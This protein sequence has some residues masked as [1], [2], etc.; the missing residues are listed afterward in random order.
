MAPGR[1]APTDAGFPTPVPALA[2]TVME[3]EITP[4]VTVR[5]VVPLVD[6]WQADAESWLCGVPRLAL[7][8]VTGYGLG[9]LN[10]HIS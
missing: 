4:P 2:G 1:L 8:S 5:L 10:T 3:I 7:V 9:L 6:A